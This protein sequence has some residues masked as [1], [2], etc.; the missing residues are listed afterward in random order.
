MTRIDFLSFKKWYQFL[1]NLDA[2][3][4]CL[5]NNFTQ[6]EV[7][8]LGRRKVFCNSRACAVGYLP[9]IFTSWTWVDDGIPLLKEDSSNLSFTDV[10]NFFSLSEQQVQQI[11]VAKNYN[12]NPTLNAC[13]RRMYSIAKSY[14]YSLNEK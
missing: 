6:G 13:L 2:K 14:G 9:T 3:R 10:A 5:K 7:S 11:A 1:D 12:T 4:F 8:F